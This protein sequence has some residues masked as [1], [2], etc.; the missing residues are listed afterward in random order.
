MIV[1]STTQRFGSSFEIRP[2]A[3]ADA[4]ALKRFVQGIGAVDRTFLDQSLLEPDHVVSWID[5]DH[6]VGLLAVDEDRVAALASVRPGTGWSSHV[7][8]LRLVVSR[9]DRGRGLGAAL[10]DRVVRLAAARGVT[11]VVIEVIAGNVAGIALFVRLGFVPEATLRDHV[12]DARGRHQDLVVLARWI[13]GHG[14]PLLDP[15]GEVAG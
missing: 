15:L 8:L 3:A 5:D 4:A 13:D 9:D 14:D 1:G 10:T 7:G 6:A 2:P 11:K 12:Q